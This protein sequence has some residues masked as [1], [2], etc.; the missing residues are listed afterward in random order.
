MVKAKKKLAN[1]RVHERGNEAGNNSGF[2]NVS[3]ATGN[4]KKSFWVIQMLMA[5]KVTG[6]DR[7]S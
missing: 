5:W 1:E 7:D 4:L 6:A 2:L 3:G